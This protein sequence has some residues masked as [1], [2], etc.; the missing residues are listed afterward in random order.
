MERSN[1]QELA[2][3]ID[4][5]L[6][7]LP[8]IK[9]PATLAPRV[10]AALAMRA[11]QP[12]W[13]KSWAHWSFGVQMIFLALSLSVAS[14]IVYAGS[15]FAPEVS[16]AP[17]LSW[18]EGYF[19][20]LEPVWQLLGA[21]GIAFASVIRSGGQ[22]LLWSTVAVATVMYLTCVG[23]GTLCYRVAFNKI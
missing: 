15:R 14:G 17:M 8:A 12:W 23:L 5:E 2:E 18:L 9:S 7:Q 6:R 16:T 20:F 10:L 22:L 11:H 4:C 13:K 21:L 3:R 1:E 19:S